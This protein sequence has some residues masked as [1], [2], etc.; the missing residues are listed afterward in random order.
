MPIIHRLSNWGDPKRFKNISPYAI[1]AQVNAYSALNL[2]TALFSIKYLSFS[3]KMKGKGTIITVRGHILEH[4][5]LKSFK[6]VG[7]PPFWCCPHL[8][9]RI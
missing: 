5:M 3:T 6:R 1:E 9:E 7:L 2:T 4:V 8:M